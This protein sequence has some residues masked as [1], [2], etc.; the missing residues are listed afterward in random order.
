MPGGYRTTSTMPF[1]RDLS[2]L[3]RELAQKALSD[4]ER[5]QQETSEARRQA[6]DQIG[7]EFRRQLHDLL[8]AGRLAELRGGDEARAP[9]VS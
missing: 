1:L 4:Q 2:A 8:G 6:A 5:R 9:P 3:D 7:E